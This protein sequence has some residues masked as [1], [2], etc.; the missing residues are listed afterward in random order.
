MRSLFLG[1]GRAGIT[2]GACA[3]LLL[4][5]LALDRHGNGHGYYHGH[6]DEHG[7]RLFTRED[8]ERTKGSGFKLTE[9]RF[10]LVMMKFLMA[11]DW[12][13]WEFSAWKGEGF[14]VT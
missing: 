1:K 2:G 10:R 5:S 13:N 8:R 4:L 12:W 9:G 3:E 14:A 7:E 6:G 11:K